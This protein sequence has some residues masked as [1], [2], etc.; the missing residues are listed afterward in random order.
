VGDGGGLEIKAEQ[1]PA[2]DDNGGGQLKPNYQV[3]FLLEGHEKAVAAVKFSNCGRYLASAS[4]DK[5]IMLWDAITG[6]HLFKFVGHSHGISDVAWS[7]RS[8]FF[9]LCVCV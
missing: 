7:T 8:T 2:C 6:E 1:G 5:T 4:A 3:K 9:P